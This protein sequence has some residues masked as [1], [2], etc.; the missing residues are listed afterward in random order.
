MQIKRAKEIAA[1][2][3]KVGESK[4]WVN[5]EE[6]EKIKEAMTK[7]DVRALIGDRII[8]KKKINE[9][10][11]GRARTLQKQKKKGRKKGAG[12]R[13]GKNT[14]RTNPKKKWMSNVRSQRKKLS[15]LKEEAK[16]S[17]I[18]STAY[19]RIRGSFFRG[20]KH[21]EEFIKGDK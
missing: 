21:L 2:L 10:S 12:K 20:R 9:H 5:P 3:L 6:G 14:A 7:E 15:E 16:K 19:K 13:K 17:G 4:I 11:R 8:K 1:K 18:Y